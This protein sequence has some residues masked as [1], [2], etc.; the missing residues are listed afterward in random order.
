MKTKVTVSA[1][2]MILLL[3]GPAAGDIIVP[4]VRGSMDSGWDAVIADKIHTGIV[5]DVITDDYMV[6]EIGK[7]FC[8]PPTPC[9]GFT[10]NVIRFRQRLDD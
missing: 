2:L 4:L 10:P 6:I 5:V 9:G 7:I 3:A 8:D 1:C